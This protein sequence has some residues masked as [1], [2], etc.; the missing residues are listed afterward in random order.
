MAKM[1]I[2]RSSAPSTTAP[3]VS[4]ASIGRAGRTPC[5]ARLAR[6]AE[7][8]TWFPS[9]AEDDRQFGQATQYQPVAVAPAQ[10]RPG[11]G[12]PHGR[13]TAVQGGER[14]HALEPGQPG[15]QAVVNAVAEGHVAGIGPG[16]V[17]SLRVGVPGRVPAGCGQR[18]DYLGEGWDDG[19]AEGDVAG[20]VPERRVRH[21]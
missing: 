4:K 7:G 9:R 14:D 20:G 15:T 18:D 8:C 11:D 13:E 2:S 17:E 3:T 10:R 12:Q 6:V 5:A 21:R 16:D 1:T 19:S